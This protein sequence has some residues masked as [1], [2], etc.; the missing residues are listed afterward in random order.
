LRFLTGRFHELVKDT[1][2]SRKADV[3]E[4]YQPLTPAMAEIQQAILE[5]MEAMIIELKRNHTLVR[6]LWLQS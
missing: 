5:C 1:L 3:V 2:A 6:M 4:L